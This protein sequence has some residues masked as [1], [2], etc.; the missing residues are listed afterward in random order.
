MNLSKA[1]DYIPH[2][3]LIAN[4]ETGG[5]QDYL[6]H[7]V[8]SYLDNTKQCLQINNEKSSWQN[9]ISGVP[10]NSIVEP[11]SLKLFLTIFCCLC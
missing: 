11:T 3:L 4:L 7:Y 10:Q 5:F 8:Y 2:D 9:I 1:F 6:V